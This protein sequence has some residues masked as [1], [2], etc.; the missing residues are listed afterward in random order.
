MKAI[1]LNSRILRNPFLVGLPSIMVNRRAQDISL[2]TNAWRPS[3]AMSDS[4]KV[5][6]SP[7][8]S[9]RQ[10]LIPSSYSSRLVQVFVDL[11]GFGRSRSTWIMKRNNASGRSGH[12]G[13]FGKVPDVA[14][15]EVGR[16][17]ETP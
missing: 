3:K 5:C 4:S 14:S 15:H 9:F 10:L 6:L 17:A 7:P 1:L 11:K 12:S 16:K 13:F 8:A 2:C